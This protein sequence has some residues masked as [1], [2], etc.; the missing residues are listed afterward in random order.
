MQML[1]CRGHYLTYEHS[2]SQLFSANYKNTSIWEVIRLA[3]IH[4]NL[5]TCHYKCIRDHKWLA[6]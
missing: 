2:G 1:K 5:I 3:G 4:V 6:W